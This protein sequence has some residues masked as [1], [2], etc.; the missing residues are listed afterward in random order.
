MTSRS[1]AAV[2][3]PSTLRNSEGPQWVQQSGKSAQEGHHSSVALSLD[4]PCQLQCIWTHYPAFVAK[5][6]AQAAT[7]RSGSGD[8][9]FLDALPVFDEHSHPSAKT[10][11][12]GPPGR[13]T[14]VCQPELPRPSLD[15]RPGASSRRTD[16]FLL[17]LWTAL[18]A[19]ENCRAERLSGLPT[20]PLLLRQTVRHRLNFLPC[21]S[22]QLP[23]EDAPLL[24]SLAP[25]PCQ[26]G[27]C[28]LPP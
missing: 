27:A 13:D 26:I 22:R 19:L 11:E 5:Q 12:P 17:R 8:L 1:S 14:T 10:Q 23:H 18:L 2:P 6:S 20:D 9:I 7:T 28:V 25:C 3:T 16:R 21:S 15:C 24:S 4:G